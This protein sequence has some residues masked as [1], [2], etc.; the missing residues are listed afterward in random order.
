ML[1]DYQNVNRTGCITLM[2]HKSLYIIPARGGSKGIPRKNIKP[3]ASI[4]L[5]HYSIAVARQLSPDDHII[6][7]TDDDE[8]AQVAR[9]TG[10]PVPYMRPAHLATDTAGSREVILDAMDYADSCSIKYDNVVLLQPT[11]PLRTVDDVKACLN[12][13]SDDVDMVVSVVEATA[14]PYYNCFETDQET[15]FLRVCKGDGQYT[16]RQD[17]PKVWEYNGA[18]YVI[19]PLSI[20]KMSLGEFTRKVPCEMPRER[21]VDL[22]TPLDWAIAEVVMNELAK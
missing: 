14:N 2:K 13:Y 15:S 6:V 7:S 17:V 10:L 8:I 22:D 18:V 20:R 16:R 9:Q 3:L 5:I 11:S 19:N 12:L 1:I 4:P 21:S